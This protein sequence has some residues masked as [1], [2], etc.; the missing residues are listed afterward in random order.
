[1]LMSD[2]TVSH[3][4]NKIK[5]KQEPDTYL[6]YYDVITICEYKQKKGRIQNLYLL[7]WRFIFFSFFLRFG[8]GFDQNFYWPKYFWRYFIFIVSTFSISIK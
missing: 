4:F 5:E 1:M 6:Q 7:Q 2:T 3:Y 8:V